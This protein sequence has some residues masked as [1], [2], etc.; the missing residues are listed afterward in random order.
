MP[1]AA[2]SDSHYTFHLFNVNTGKHDR[3]T[4]I[5]IPSVTTIIGETLAKPMLVGWAYRT[6][7][8]HIAGLVSVLMEDQGLHY[9]DRM[10]A[11][12]DMLTDADMLE[13]YLK[14]NQLRPDDIKSEAADRGTIAHAL[15][16]RLADAYLEADEVAAE[17]IAKRTLASTKVSGWERAVADWWVQR[18]PRVVASE[19]KLI[20]LKH[21]FIG[22][23]D[24][25][26]DSDEGLTLTDLKSR[27]TQTRKVSDVYQSDHIQC[28]AYTI[29]WD[30][31]E[32]RPIERTTVLVVREDGSWDEEA[33][34]LDAE[35]I[36]LD[37]LSAYEKLKVR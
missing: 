34:L 25:I 22:T 10:A 8:D 37:L 36:F 17:R 31:T 3:Q 9:S 23:C 12:I 2:G 35:G 1:R 4:V 19:Q 6:T 11:V 16:E 15:L 7:R 32:S 26:Y 29:A 28:G 18:Y 33:T 13:E 27:K 20:S 14:E 5:R 21:G 30:E 24:L